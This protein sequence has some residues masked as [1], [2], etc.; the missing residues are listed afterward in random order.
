MENIRK[1]PRLIGL[2]SVLLPVAIGG[3]WSYISTEAQGRFQARST[4]V[5]VTVYP[6][7][8]VKGGQ[9]LHDT[10]L[11]GR[12]ATMLREEKLASPQLA[13]TPVAIPVQWGANQAKMAQRSANAFA[14]AVRSAA[15]PTDYALLAEILCNP[16]ETQVI[17]VH[18]F[19]ADR[20][21]LLADGGLTNSHRDEFQQVKPRNREG[22]Y[23][24]L[25]P[26]L[27]GNWR[28]K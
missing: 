18:Y 14:D 7:Q 16:D 4:P 5:S 6:V 28:H 23:E 8:V 13:T 3:C 21:G 11:A 17:G 20:T 15:I 12:L 9:R 27:R 19:L 26:M 25:I 24:V 2:L 1:I 10:A 22:G